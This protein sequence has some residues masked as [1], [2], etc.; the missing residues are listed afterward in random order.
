MSKLLWCSCHLDHYLGIQS[1]Q[2]TWRMHF[3]SKQQHFAP[4]HNFEVLELS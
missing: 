1:A 4:Q 3:S 2:L